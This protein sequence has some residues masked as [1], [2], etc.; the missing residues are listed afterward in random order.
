MIT[1]LRQFR[2]DLGLRQEEIA[3]KIGVTRQIYGYVEQGKRMGTVEFWQRLQEVFS[4]PP[5][6]LLVIQKSDL[7]AYN[8]KL[9]KDK[10]CK[11]WFEELR[12]SNAKQ[13]KNHS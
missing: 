2:S 1:A 7:K 6:L 4:V 9:F 3:E 13:T 8:E 5:N 10:E 11:K 12:L